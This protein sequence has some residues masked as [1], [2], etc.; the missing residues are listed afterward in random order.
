MVRAGAGQAERVTIPLAR[1]AFQHWDGSWRT[2]PGEYTVH[3]GSSVAGL[4]L[5]AQVSAP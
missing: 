4:P 1:R 3:A 5:T 2:E